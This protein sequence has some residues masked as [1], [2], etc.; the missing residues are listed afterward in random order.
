MSW[1]PYLSTHLYSMS[2]YHPNAYPYKVI[3]TNKGTSV[4][5]EFQTEAKALKW[6]TKVSKRWRQG[7]LEVKKMK[8]QGLGEIKPWST[9]TKDKEQEPI[10]RPSKVE[11]DFFL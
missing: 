11:A 5:K 9:Y 2:R 6:A 10:D 4:I 1:N 3:N 8:N 7:I